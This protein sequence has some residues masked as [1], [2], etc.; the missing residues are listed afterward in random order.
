MLFGDRFPGKAGKI[1]NLFSEPLTYWNNAAYTFKRHAGHG[2]R[3]EMDLHGCTFPI[4]TNL[5]TQ[6]SGAAQ[7]IE[8]V[9]HSHLKKRLRK[10][11]GNLLLLSIQF[12]FVA[13]LVCHCVG[14]VMMP[15][16]TLR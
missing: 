1:Y 16:I 8:V 2:T 11:G 12:F 15:N 9:L 7:P 3:G 5:L 14:I 6:I 10:I 13:D 4:L